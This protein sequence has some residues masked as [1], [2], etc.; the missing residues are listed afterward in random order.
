M[1]RQPR[2][3]S[4]ADMAHV[5]S[6]SPAPLPEADEPVDSRDLC[7]V[8]YT[9]GSTGRPKGVMVEHRN[10][11]HL[12]AAEQRIFG[13]HP[14]DR[15]FQGASL[16]FDL[17]VEE[18]WLAFGAGAT[19]IAAPPDVACA[20]PDLAMHLAEAGVT[21]L[22][23]VPTLLSMLDAPANGL[24]ALRLLI[25]GGET[26]PSQLIQRWSRPGRRIV[27][28]YGPTETTVIASYADVTPAS[29][30]PSAARRLATKFIFWRRTAAGA[31]G[32]DRRNLHW[33]S[34]RRTRISRAR[35]ETLR[36]LCA[37]P[38]RRGNRG[39][40]AD[41]SQRRPRPPERATATSSS[42]AAPTGR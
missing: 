36:P 34:R 15:V 29:R 32:R 11:C 26:C 40:G 16:S 2:T 9:S 8:I 14:G 12:V 20:G 6:E 38:F 25:L 13:V 33:R 22:S 1:P 5:G 30:L 21:V 3:L 17:S 18:I 31:A 41:V 19:L 23:C 7:Y 35:A 4:A 39:G 37:R 28:T 42:W 10:A 27:N 24:P